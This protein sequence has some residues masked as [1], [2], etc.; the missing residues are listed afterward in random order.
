M[1]GPKTCPEIHLGHHQHVAPRAFQ[2]NHEEYDL[3]SYKTS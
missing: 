1:A 2:R 3:A